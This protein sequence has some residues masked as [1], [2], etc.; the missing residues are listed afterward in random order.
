MIKIWWCVIKI[1]WCPFKIQKKE[2]REQGT[3]YI[4]LDIYVSLK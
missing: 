4:S 3:A 2:A 1:C